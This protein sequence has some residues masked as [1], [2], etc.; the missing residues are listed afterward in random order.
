MVLLGA[1]DCRRIRALSG[2]EHGTMSR[3]MHLPSQAI[4]HTCRHTRLNGGTDCTS[5]A[6][7]SQKAPGYMKDK[8]TPNA[9]TRTPSLGE[10]Q[11]RYRHARPTFRA[12]APSGFSALDI[13]LQ[14]GTQWPGQCNGNPLHVGYWRAAP[15]KCSGPTGRQASHGQR[16][17]AQPSVHERGRTPHGSHG[18]P[19][20][21]GNGVQ[22]NG[23]D[24]VEHVGDGQVD[25][26][27]L[28]RS[29][30]EE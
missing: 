29:A 10:T 1:T 24:E 2:Q 9:F 6:L 4:S 5:S 11:A 23:K 18:M 17:G 16:Y 20:L 12:E 25:S 30:Q 21:V 15:K 22:P 26:R 3:A 13:I 19:Q 7:M 8:K 27:Q 14:L 28:R